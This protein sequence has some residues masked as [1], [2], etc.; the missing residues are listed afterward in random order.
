MNGSPNPFL[1][2]SPGADSAHS[3]AGVWVTAPES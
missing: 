1:F 2:H 3:D